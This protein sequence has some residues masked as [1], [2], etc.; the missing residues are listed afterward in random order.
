MPELK[1]DFRRGKMNKDLDE[2]LVPNGEF[3]DALN[4]Q[5]AGSEASEVGSAQNIL[6][7]RLAYPVSLLINGGQCVGH[8]RDT[9]NNKI[10]WFIYGNSVNAIAEYDQYTKTV[11]PVLVDTRSILNLS[12]LPEYRITAINIIE[13]ILFWTDNLNEPRRVDVEKFKAGSTNFS[14]HTRLKDQNSSLYD[15]T[16][17]DITVIKKA[18]IQPPTITM[19]DTLRTGIV[20]GVLTSTQFTGNTNAGIGQDGEPLDPGLY[21]FNTTGVGVGFLKLNGNTGMNLQVGDRVRVTLLDETEDDEV[22]LSIISISTAFPYIFEC[23]IDSISSGIKTGNQDW[24]TELIQDK[25]LFE[26]KF[27]RFAY[28]YKYDDGQYSS[29]GPFSE[30]AFLPGEFDYNP[31]KGYNLGMVNTLKKLNISNFRTAQMPKDVVEIDIL[32]KEDTNTNVYTVQTIKGGDGQLDPEWVANNIEVDSEIIYK[33]LPSMELLRPY[34]NVPKKAKAQEFVANRLVYGNYT[35]QYDLV[36]SDNEI[37][38][39][40]FTVS[41]VQDANQAI[42]VREPG[43]SLKS[44][45][46]YQIGVVYKDEYG[47]ETPVLTDVSGSIQI[48]K[49]QA[50]NYNV[51]QVKLNSNPPS[52]ATHYKYFIKEVSDQ[53]YNL[54][55]D[56]HY[57]AEDG[58]V[59]LAFPSSERN[60]VQEDTFIILKKRHDSDV[61]VEE[62]AKYKILAIENEAPDFLTVTKVSKGTAR[63]DSNGDLFVENGY[64]EAGTSL[65]RI[66][67]E[68]WK[69]SFG[70]TTGS[71]DD[72]DLSTASIHTQTD[73]LV[74][75]KRGNNVT[76]YY[77]VANII[78]EPTK[79][80]LTYATGNNVSIPDDKYW[81]VKIEGTFDESDVSWLGSTGVA[82]SLI[83]DTK[84]EI[85][86]AQKVRKLKPEFSGRFF[87]KVYRDSVLERNILKFNNIDELRILAQEQFWQVAGGPNGGTTKDSLGYNTG[88][89]QSTRYNYWR[90]ANKGIRSGNKAA[91][92]IARWGEID[93]WRDIGGEGDVAINRDLGPDYT[94]GGPYH[95]QL[96]Q[97]QGYGIRAGHDL[98]EIAYHWFGD[99][100]PNSES[101]QHA[102]WTGEWNKFGNT[103][104]PGFKDF[105]DGLETVGNYIKF[106]GDPDETVYKIE[107][108]R[109]GAATMYNGRNSSG[110][111]RTGTNPSSRL[112]LWTIKLDKPIT[113][114][115]E[116]NVSG[117]RSSNN[118]T[119]PIQIGTTFVDENDNEGFSSTNPA[120][121]ETEPKEVA[122]LDIYFEGS[123]GYP[124]AD[125][126]NL[127]T[128]GY[129][130]CFSFAN[131]VE[132]N[133]VRDDFNASMIAKGV[134]AS[135]VLAEQYK[136]ENKKTGLIYSQIFNSRAG[137]NRLNQF[138]M[139]DKITKD[140][141]PEYGSIQ[142][143][144]TRETDVLAFCEDKIVKVLANKDALYNADGNANLTASRNV[145]GQAVVPPTFGEFGI[146][147]NPESFANYTYRCY[148]TDKARGKVLRLSMDGVTEI[149][150][151]GMK[152]YF[153][154]KLALSENLILGSYDDNKDLYNVTPKSQYIRDFAETISFK[155][156]VQGWPSR[157]S[158]HANEGGLSLNNI[159]YTFYQGDLWS[160]DN[161]TRNNFYGNQ[162]ESTVKLIFNDAPDAVKGFNTLNYEGTQT[163]VI[164][165]LTNS[166]YFDNTEKKGWYSYSITTDLQDGKVQ[167]FMDKENKWFGYIQGTETT[168]DTGS[169]TGTLDTNEFSVQGIG[170]PTSVTSDAPT[171]V[172]ITI[173]ENND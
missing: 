131:G 136:E 160:H 109:R 146:S 10:Y 138:I 44:M 52:W 6:G 46:T 61:F 54:A 78:Y 42:V 104:E 130:N 56:R 2:R 102:C 72:I 89:S 140:L 85:E 120:I 64:P 107:G 30:V 16:K 9:E 149:S 101:G 88:G 112:V 97:I 41:V 66:P 38:T 31:K 117:L 86:I 60:K 76:K 125:H 139:A 164:R 58:N 168:W 73:L 71:S 50:I 45:R 15:F 157:K 110:N 65:I 172:T 23:N 8:V 77:D 124:I 22:I 133:R 69:T 68:Q 59:W 142:L 96:K 21:P 155:E 135:T 5:V 170:Q 154:D 158:F 24:K 28:R 129:H 75:I 51:F 20:E 99:G 67:K 122:E 151:Y 132:S 115:P 17:H 98:I 106:A 57:P 150:N 90:N 74:R 93:W 144:H 169:Q 134:K 121:W 111:G 11:S 34:D 171:N 18:P 49:E 103:V 37:I 87:A 53:Y 14:T 40:K 162:Y 12:R 39:P 81:E 143:L 29:M 82:N 84:I 79:S 148:F 83:R 95:N 94:H 165:D 4:I 147:K 105:V 145:L 173:V 100:F 167:Q 91:W 7:N 33:V 1:R 13:G 63:A 126:S 161:N 3:R 119:T 92:H 152:D 127:K 35:D 25:K 123:E 36:D 43:K 26:F 163:K 156:E 118:N 47:S 19:S 114:A 128:L 108:Y 27:P 113:W 166:E 153:R 32:Y 62:E 116:D 137:V 48:P 141:N 55:M 159:Y 70:G 80:G